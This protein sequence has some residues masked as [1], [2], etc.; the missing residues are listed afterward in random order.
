VEITLEENPFAWYPIEFWITLQ[1]VTDSTVVCDVWNMVQLPNG[2][3]YGP[4]MGPA[5]LILPDGFSG[6]RLMYQPVPGA[7]PCGTYWYEGRV[8]IYPDTIW[9]TSGFEFEKLSLGDDQ[10]ELGDWLCTGEL[11]PGESVEDTDLSSSFIL[12][13]TFPNPFNSATTVRFDLPEASLVSLIVYDTR[14]RLV[15]NLADG[16]REVGSHELLFDGSD[17]PSGIYL[18]R[19][20]TGDQIAIGKMLLLK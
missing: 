15:A 3:W 10:W 14:G 2:S 11:F 4:T 12:H 9:D 19:F 6:T 1:N 20:T 17:L 16:W 13:G 18:Y 7:A 8:G 5:N